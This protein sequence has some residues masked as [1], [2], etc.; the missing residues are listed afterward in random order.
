LLIFDVPNQEVPMH[1]TRVLGF[2]SF[3]LVLAAQVVVAQ[4]E[5]VAPQASSLAAVETGTAPVGHFRMESRIV[6]GEPYS[7][8]RTTTFTQTLA[9]GTTISRATTT[10]EARDSGGRVYRETQIAPTGSPARTLYTVF[11]PVN[12]TRTS[13]RSDTKQASITQL[14]NIGGRGQ[15]HAARGG[16][17]SPAFQNRRGPAPAVEQLGTKTIEG[18]DATGTRS[19]VTFPVGAFGNSRPV[20]VTHERWVAADLGIT[21][22]ETDSDPRTGVRTAALSNI[23]RTEPDAAL[24][25]APEGYA[26]AEHTAGAQF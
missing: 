16:A 11:D 7:A 2:A 3:S 12:R 15:W 22:L 13:W 4:S 20:T 23:Q 14:P 24:F 19:T 9:D 18:I 1:I 6:T 26:V 10:K 25:H 21:V 5:S 17:P 8:V